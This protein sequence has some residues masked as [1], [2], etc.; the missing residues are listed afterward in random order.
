MDTNITINDF[1]DIS[2]IN[3]DEHGLNCKGVMLEV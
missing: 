1:I 3:S 2:H